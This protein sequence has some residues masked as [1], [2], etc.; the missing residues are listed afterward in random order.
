MYHV[1]CMSWTENQ[2]GKGAEVIFFFRTLFSVSSRS[3]HYPDH[4]FIHLDY[5]L[6]PKSAFLL[7]LSLLCCYASSYIYIIVMIFCPVK[8]LGSYKV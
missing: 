8:I 4:L 6:V 1:F 5:S 7:T 2:N 3:Y